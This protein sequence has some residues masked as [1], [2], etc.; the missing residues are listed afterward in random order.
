MK[1][2][3]A[4]TLCFL[5]YST[6]ALA[7]QCMSYELFVSEIAK[8]YGEHRYGAG[9]GE[10]GLI[11]LF[12]NPKSGDFTIIIRPEPSLACMIVAGEDWKFVI[13]PKPVDKGTP[14]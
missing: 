12:A 13:P 11:E 7:Q 2:L 5:L 6:S 10:R 3:L 9:T 1:K 14:S 4:L 8:K